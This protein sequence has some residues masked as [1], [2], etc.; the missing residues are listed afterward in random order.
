[1]LSEVLVGKWK[2]RKRGAHAGE[3]GERRDGVMRR[4]RG[5]AGGTRAGRGE[6]GGRVGG[7]SKSIA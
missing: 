7:G 6:G 5:E 3:R 1:M 4:I 2:K